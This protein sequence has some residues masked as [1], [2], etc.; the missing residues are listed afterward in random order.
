ML[1]ANITKTS[2]NEWKN[3]WIENKDKL[4]PNRK[5]GKEIQAYLKEK[6]ILEEIKDKK[7]KEVVSWNI[8]NNECF[9]VKLPKGTKPDAVTYYVLLDS[10][11]G[12]KQK[13]FI[14]I[15]LITGY[16]IVEGNQS[17]WDEL[18]AFRGLDEDDIQNPYCVA[19]YLACIKK[20]PQ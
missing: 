18:Y 14:G 7:A 6:Y 12:Q 9:S 8:L 19:E 10:D 3:I 17:L 15:D 13:I 11:K 2:L 16:Y 20:F 4:K 5:S 1:F